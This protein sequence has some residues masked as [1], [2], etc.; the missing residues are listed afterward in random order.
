MNLNMLIHVCQLTKLLSASIE[1]T[2][3]RFLICMDPQMVK[4][5]VPESEDFVAI[6]VSAAEQSDDRF[7]R[8]EASVLIDIVFSCFWS[9]LRVNCS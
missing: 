6:W 4:E 1:A 3:K 5:I 2:S 8:L 7:E 9:I